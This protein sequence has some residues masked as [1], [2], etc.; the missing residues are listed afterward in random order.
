MVYN[1][2]TEFHFYLGA[3]SVDQVYARAFGLNLAINRWYHV[4]GTYDGVNVRI[5]ID[6]VLKGTT[7]ANIT[8]GNTGLLTFG[9][10]DLPGVPYYLPGTLDEV[11]IWNVART[12]SEIQA[13][14]NQTLTGSES[15]LAGY[16]RLN[17]G[18][19]QIVVDST[20][21]G[22]NGQLGSTSGIDT[23]DPIWVL[24]TAP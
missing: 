7:P 16:W 10:H 22:N 11:R 21:N 14:M 15:G 2:S 9:Y 1:G 8:I 5:Y 4:A 3:N 13:T 18:S 20:A 19:G 12:A 17:E 24:S 6:G 23:D